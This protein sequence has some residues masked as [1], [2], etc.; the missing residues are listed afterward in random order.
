MRYLSSCSACLKLISCAFCET[1]TKNSNECYPSTSTSQHVSRI[2]HSRVSSAICFQCSVRSHIGHDVTSPP[3]WHVWTTATLR[4]W[5]FAE[6]L[7]RFSAICTQ[8]RSQVGVSGRMIPRRWS[9]FPLTVRAEVVFIGRN[10]ISEQ[11]EQE[12]KNTAV[13]LQ[14]YSK[15]ILNIVCLWNRINKIE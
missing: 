1:V 2:L 14:K 5:Q 13:K 7:A 6:R 8:A 9:T 10:V 3:G 12:K 4:H 11:R 15:H